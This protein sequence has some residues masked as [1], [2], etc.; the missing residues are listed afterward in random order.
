MNHEK[1]IAILSD[2]RQEV[3]AEREV[4]LQAEL[5]IAKLTKLVEDI[6]A[7]LGVAE[8][9]ASPES[10][11]VNTL[12]EN[13][14]ATEPVF[15]LT[16]PNR[17]SHVHDRPEAVDRIMRNAA[18]EITTGDIA[19]QL[20][21]SGDGL[22]FTTHDFWRIVD[23]VLRKGAKKGRYMK[24]GKARWSLPEFVGRQMPAKAS[25]GGAHEPENRS[26]RIWAFMRREGLDKMTAT[27]I[28]RE[29]VSRGLERTNN[30]RV[31]SN[32]IY[33]AMLRRPDL[34]T[35]LGEGIWSPV[36]RPNS[37]SGTSNEK[38]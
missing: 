32:S 8:R 10:A 34:F 5:R 26:E 30:P 37:P 35:N 21:A 14:H 22:Q 24:T 11:R 7:V 17:E 12:K 36:D 28:A 25:N 1:W 33:G 4:A 38:D 20:R 19:D 15:A 6:E 9:P 2:A 29:V 23:S 13:G 18:G 31:L 3:A 16:P 27:G